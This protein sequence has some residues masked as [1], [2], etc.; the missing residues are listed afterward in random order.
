MTNREKLIELARGAID[1]QLKMQMDAEIYRA[2]QE[3]HIDVD[4]EELIKALRHDRNQYDK[5]YADG[6][7]EAIKEFAE[8]VKVESH[9]ITVNEEELH[10][11][12][13]NIVKE[14]EEQNV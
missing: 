10:N 7:A 13:D 12:I 11:C 6:R 3:M 1:P 4:E 8:R 5:G 9:Y 14:M 2:I